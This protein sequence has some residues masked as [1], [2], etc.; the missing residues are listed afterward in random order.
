MQTVKA[1]I[2]GKECTPSLVWVDWG[3]EGGGREVSTGDEVTLK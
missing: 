2:Y 1:T 3:G